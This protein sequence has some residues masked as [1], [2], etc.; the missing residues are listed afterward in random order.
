MSA[1]SRTTT[2]ILLLTLV[3]VEWGGLTVLRISR[4]SATARH[5]NSDSLARV[6]PMPASS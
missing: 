1:D 2:G 5:C 3:A 4:G 6:T